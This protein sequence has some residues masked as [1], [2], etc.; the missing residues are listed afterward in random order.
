MMLAVHR[1]PLSLRRKPRTLSVLPTTGRD[2]RSTDIVRL[3]GRAPGVPYSARRDGGITV[4]SH[5]A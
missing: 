5:S 4:G 1:P 2:R 3:N